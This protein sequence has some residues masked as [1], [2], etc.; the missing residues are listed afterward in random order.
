MKNAKHIESTQRFCSSKR[1]YTI[2]K[3]NKAVTAI[4]DTD[5][6]SVVVRV[7]GTLDGPSVVLVSAFIGTSDGMSVAYSAVVVFL[8]RLHPADS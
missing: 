7:S 1:G 8:N 2:T 3:R 5:L 4:A 6:E